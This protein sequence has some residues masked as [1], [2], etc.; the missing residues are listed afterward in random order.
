[1]CYPREGEIRQRLREASARIRKL[2]GALRDVDTAYRAEVL[3]LQGVHDPSDWQIC[4]IVRVA[5][6]PDPPMVNH[7]TL[8]VLE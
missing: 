6:S 8:E 7:L 1:M 3:R 2:E 4:A 5:L